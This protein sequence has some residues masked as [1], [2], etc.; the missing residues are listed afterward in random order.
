MIPQIVLDELYIHEIE[1]YEKDVKELSRITEN[2]ASLI[3]VERRFDLMED[4]KS[5][6]RDKV[7]EF[8]SRHGEVEIM[9]VCDERYFKDIVEKASWYILT[10]TRRDATLPV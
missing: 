5:F 10:N 8:L 2:M 1:S 7:Q 9:P 4:Y 6:L 3:S